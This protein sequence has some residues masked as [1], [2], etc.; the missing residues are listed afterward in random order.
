MSGIRKMRKLAGISVRCLANKVGVS[1]MSI[2]RYEQ[3]KRTPDVE[4]AKRI[5]DVLNCTIVDLM[6]KAG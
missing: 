5:A 1:M 6:M 3:G 2:Y 4:T